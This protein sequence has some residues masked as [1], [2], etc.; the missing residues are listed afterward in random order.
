MGDGA[1]DIW[2]GLLERVFSRGRA[3]TLLALFVLESGVWDMVF[4]E[5]GGGGS[6]TGPGTG[7]EFKFIFADDIDGF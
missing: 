1:G 4:V 5:R 6:G 2:R 7:A 3:S